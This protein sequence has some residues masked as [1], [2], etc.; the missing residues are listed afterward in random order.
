[1]EEEAGKLDWVQLL[2]AHGRSV[3]CTLGAA[4]ECPHLGFTVSIFKRQT[5]SLPEENSLIH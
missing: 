4:G 3:G 2:K 5:G 1:M